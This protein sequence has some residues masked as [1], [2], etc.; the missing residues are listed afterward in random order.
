VSNDLDRGMKPILARMMT[1]LEQKV[2]PSHSALIVMDVQNDFCAKEGVFG[3]EGKNLNLI[4]AMVPRL[5]NFIGRAREVGL[6]IIYSRSTHSSEGSHYLSDAYVAQQKRWV[7]GRYTEYP[8]CK[9]GS[10]GA[11]FY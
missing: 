3:K 5:I 10:W 6:T 2:Y 9:E 1:T 4:Q 11:D 8:F 7:Q